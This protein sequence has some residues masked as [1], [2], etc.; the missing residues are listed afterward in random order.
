MRFGRE[1]V[2]SVKGCNKEGYVLKEPRTGDKE[3]G[4][5]LEV[6]APAAGD[7][8]TGQARVG[9][10]MALSASRIPRQNALC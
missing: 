7:A 3:V 1:E 5:A 2:I 10:R 6:E 4:K 9:G 8:F